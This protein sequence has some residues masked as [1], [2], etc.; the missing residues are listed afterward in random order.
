MLPQCLDH[1]Q[2]SV[3]ST[4]LPSLRA[5]NSI[6]ASDSS[7]AENPIKAWAIHTPSL[8]RRGRLWTPGFSQ[9]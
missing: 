3:F 7:L 5:K 1:R 9:Y 6:S 2:F 4:E 8:S